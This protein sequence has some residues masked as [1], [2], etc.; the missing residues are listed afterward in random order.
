MLPLNPQ[1]HQRRLVNKSTLRKPAAPFSVVLLVVLAASCQ[2]KKQRPVALAAV[3]HATALPAGEKIL[4]KNRR[5]VYLVR[6]YAPAATTAR[7]DTVTMTASGA[8]CSFEA[9]QTCFEWSFRPDTLWTAGFKGNVGAV[10]NK[11][12]FWIHPPRYG[13]YRILE[14]N[15]FPHIKLPATPGRK[16]EWKIYAPD[17]FA[18]PTWATWKGVLP[19]KFRYILGNIVQLHT[20]LGNL[21][22][23]RVHAEG[24]SRLGCTTLEAYFHPTYGFVRLDYRNID[25]SRVQL[26][27]LAVDT[28]P[29]SNMKTVAQSLNLFKLDSSVARL[30]EQE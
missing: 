4:T 22:C 3:S 30:N 20:P 29:E 19:V 12:E 28:R 24:I 5:F 11:A 26:E 6:W 10:E 13:H 17:Y 18:D 8:P 27:M 25:A 9:T 21:P 15:P 14:F 16:W 7:L 1:L 2:S 23:S